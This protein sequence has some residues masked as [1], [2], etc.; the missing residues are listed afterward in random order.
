MDV[1]EEKARENKGMDNTTEGVGAGSAGAQPARRG[2]GRPLGSKTRPFAERKQ[3]RP[4]HATPFHAAKSD[5]T[6][7]EF[8]AIRESLGYSAKEL[9]RAMGVSAYYV[10]KWEHGASATA[11]NKYKANAVV[12]EFVPRYVALAL[13]G[14]D[15][16]RRVGHGGQVLKALLQAVGALDE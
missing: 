3:S 6:R 4:R 5:M 13:R 12:E 16:E 9:A 14:L 10:D 11:R 2:P 15:L 8:R 1:S 7:A